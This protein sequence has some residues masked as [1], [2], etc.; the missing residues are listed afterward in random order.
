MHGAGNTFIVIDETDKDLE[1]I[2]DKREF[3]REETLSNNVDGA[4]FIQTDNG[5]IKMQ[6]FDRDGTEEMCGNGVRCVARY[7]YDHGHINKDDFI[8]TADGLKHVKIINDK[9]IEVNMG[10]PR[11]F[12]KLSNEMYF[13]YVGLAHIVKFVNH[14]N[15]EDAFKEGREIRYSKNLMDSVNHPEGLHVNFVNFIDRSNIE[16][17]TYEVGVEDITKSCG[18][19]NIA[20]AYAVLRVKDCKSPVY[21]HNIGGILEIDLLDGELLLK[22]PA[23]YF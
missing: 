23:E 19:G 18:T 16:L 6:Y 3:V 5:R 17:I 10:L 1:K 13:V 11:E 9:L 14:L 21:A 2:L 20:S 4:L 7:S 22:G 15:K 12:K 8:D